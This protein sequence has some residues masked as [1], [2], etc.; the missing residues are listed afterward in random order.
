MSSPDGFILIFLS[1]NRCSGLTENNIY[2]W[3]NL[4]RKVTERNFLAARCAGHRGEVGSLE[5]S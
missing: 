3:S 4:W 5:P 2:R 1:N